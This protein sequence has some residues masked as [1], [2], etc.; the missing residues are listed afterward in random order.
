MR[1]RENLCFERRKQDQLGKNGGG[2]VAPANR[3]SEMGRNMGALH[4]PPCPGSQK[5][6]ETGAKAWQD[7]RKWRKSKNC[8]HCIINKQRERTARE[9]RRESTKNAAGPSRGVTPVERRGGGES[10]RKK[11]TEMILTESSCHLAPL[12]DG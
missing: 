5:G 9:G 6:G 12:V 1:P 4:A 7:Q 3:L 11:H 2:K 10:D 8:Q